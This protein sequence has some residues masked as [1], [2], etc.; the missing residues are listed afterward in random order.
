MIRK[1]YI[2]KIEIF[3]QNIK[4][5]SVMDASTQTEN[6]SVISRII[7][8]FLMVLLEQ[9]NEE[10]SK[11][12]EEYED[13]IYDSYFYEDR[14]DVLADQYM[15]SGSHNKYNL[16][17]YDSVDDFHRGKSSNAKKKSK[18]SVSCGRIIDE[19]DMS[20]DI[21]SLGC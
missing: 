11:L 1:V 15:E 13:D 8:A 21:N 20:E 9:K 12:D 19:Y 14:F 2:Y 3:K 17:I 18:R 6:I 7:E 10:D 4:D 5:V 16:S